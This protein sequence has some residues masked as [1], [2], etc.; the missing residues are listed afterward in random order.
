MNKTVISIVCSGLLIAGAIL[1]IGGKRDASPFTSTE[2]QNNVQVV[3]GKQIIEINAKGGFQP[4]VS[5][6]KAGVPTV[7]RFNTKGTF[8][9]SSSI[10]IPSLN[11]SKILPQSG[12]TD[13][14]IGVS[15]LAKLEGTCGM[16]MYPFEINFTS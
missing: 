7:L 3:D 14:D 15:S 2:N 9:C 6:A 8:D 16:G 1:W 13:I 12:S 4:E 5:I 11:I 10:S